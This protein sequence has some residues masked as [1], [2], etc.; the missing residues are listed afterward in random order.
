M[1]YPRPWKGNTDFELTKPNT[2]TI[3]TLADR[4]QNGKQYSAMLALL[5]GSVKDGADLRYM[6]LINAEYV[7]R[8]AFKLYEIDTKVEGVYSCPACRHNNIHRESGDEDTRDDVANLAVHFD[9]RDEQGL[10]YVMELAK[11][12]EVEIWASVEGEKKQVAILNKYSFRDPLLDDLIKI[13]GDRT[14]DTSIKRL[15][16]LFRMCIVDL[17][18]VIDDANLTVDKIK[19]RYPEDILNF[20]DFRD[21]Q[22]M[23]LI[24]R[25]YGLEHFIP[26]GCENCGKHF[27]SA[28]DF[29]GFFV[30]ALTSIS[31]PR[32]ERSNG[33][34]RNGD[35]IR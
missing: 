10:P 20:P 6:P 7:V 8:E 34:S 25:E 30:S 22:E 16:K 18:G 29:T 27:E 17:D 4:A 12:R 11:G 2:Q 23:S 28:V 5:E 15:N 9:E 31:A 1:R 35:S 32:T 26:I 24:T 33:R 19:T 14:L 13:E 21:F 3:L